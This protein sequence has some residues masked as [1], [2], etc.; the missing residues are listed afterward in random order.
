M[1]LLLAVP[2]LCCLIGPA[3]HAAA[4]PPPPLSGV[5][6]QGDALPAG[7]IA[8]LG[9]GRFRM[10][11]TYSG[12]VAL[13]GDGKTIAGFRYHNNQYQITLTDSTTGQEVRA[14]PARGSGGPLEFTRDGKELVSVNYDGAFRFY[15]IAQ[16]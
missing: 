10:G 4:P 2:L 5:D 12:S 1:R 14:I 15:D 3:S 8:R 16:G 7:A 13:S 6:P 11:G 9:T